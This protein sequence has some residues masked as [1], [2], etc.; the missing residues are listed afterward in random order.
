MNVGNGER[1]RDGERRVV[2]SL[3][4]LF[5][6]TAIKKKKSKNDLGN[7]FFYF[8]REKREIEKG[9]IHVQRKSQTPA[10]LLPEAFFRSPL[11][12]TVVYMTYG[13]GWFTPN[14]WRNRQTSTRHRR[15]CTAC[16]ESDRSS[17]GR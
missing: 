9:F 13:P 14:G 2:I 7:V 8:Q 5:Y 11:E 15:V 6:D 16:L 12:S 3:A 1:E 4:K 17:C 10:E